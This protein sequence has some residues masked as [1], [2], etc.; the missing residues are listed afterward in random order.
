MA[1]EDKLQRIRNALAQ[2]DPNNNEHW[3]DEN[4]PRTA[5]VQRIVNDQTVKRGDIQAANPNFVRPQVGDPLG[6][7]LGD[8]VEMTG[9]DVNGK[10][11]DVAPAAASPAQE[12][13]ELMTEAEVKQVLLDRVNAAQMVLNTA[14][15]KIREGH[16]EEA[17]S[18]KALNA[19]IADFK[20][21]FP[22]LTPAQNIKAH[23][24]G[25]NLRRMQSVQQRG[26]G[27]A[28]QVD[29]SMQRGNRRGWG[30]PV[31]GVVGADGNLIKD[32]AGNVVQPRQMQTRAQPFTI[33]S[34][35][36]RPA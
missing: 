26:P 34:Q 10:P 28:S 24:A 15:A 8:P 25:E 17:E 12:Q 5:V 36:N 6:D 16:R 32:A 13:G 7:P 29:Q 18:H 14:Q 22:P 1:D 11:A 20:R 27:S 23:I 21:Q 2:L 35:G 3:T 30:R 9:P 19:A 33:P 31:R 4:L